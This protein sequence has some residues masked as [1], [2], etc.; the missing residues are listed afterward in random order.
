M[1]RLDSPA[2]QDGVLTG[3][4]RWQ[5]RPPP[6]RTTMVG[7]LVRVEPF[8]VADHAGGLF[9][10]F[11]DDPD[12]LLWRYRDVG[13]FATTQS[14]AAYAQAAM[15]G[16]SQE[17]FTI[18]DQASDQP[19]GSACYMNIVPLHGTIEVG[20]ISFSNWLKRT[21]QATEA[22]YLMARRVFDELG[23]RRYEWKCDSANAPSRAAAQRL[24]FTP[25][26]VFRNHMVIKGRNRDT[27]WF[28]ITGEEWPSRRNAMERW[29]DDANFDANG[30]Q[31]MRLSEL[32]ATRTA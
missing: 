15:T 16:G 19:L 28:S 31:K 5:P 8:S 2:D 24:G 12:G 6:P 10:A 1:T 27:A 14:F 32:N 22:M 21:P 30:V 20:T 4:A 29:L 18:V 13:P 23:Y 26:G 17:F 11:R 9:E 3:L 25:E 7:R